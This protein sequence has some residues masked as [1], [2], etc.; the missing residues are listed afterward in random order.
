MLEKEDIQLIY[1]H[2]QFLV[3]KLRCE[4]DA[5]DVLQLVFEKFLRNSYDEK[6]A[7]RPIFERRKYIKLAV[8]S[9]LLDFWR[10]KKRN[11]ET[12]TNQFT[13]QPYTIYDESQINI[14]IELCD[15]VLE[16]RQKQ[17][18]K[19]RFK[20]KKFGEIASLLNIPLNT[21]LGSYRYAVLKL[22]EYKNQL[23]A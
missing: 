8:K 23:A 10:G 21:A 14:L 4:H 1:S 3:N 11:P 17:V 12:L 15:Q 2:R 19:E 7:G 18:V 20:G 13:D 22:Q 9:Q 6:L 16:G 5:D